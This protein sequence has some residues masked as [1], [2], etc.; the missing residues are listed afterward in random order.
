MKLTA[1]HTE[2]VTLSQC[3]KFTLAIQIVLLFTASNPL[4]LV[5]DT[6]LCF[7]ATSADRKFTLR[8]RSCGWYIGE[9]S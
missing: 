8:E 3:V 6:S 5:I 9:D 1:K 7:V 2:H 4:R